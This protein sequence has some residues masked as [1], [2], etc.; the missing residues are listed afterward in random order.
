MI[1]LAI[2]GVI[3][4][5]ILALA[6]L[7]ALH[8]LRPDIHPGRTMIS[9]YAVGRHGWLMFVCFGGLA[10]ASLCLALV[11][12]PRL[13]SFLGRVG[14]VF[15]VAAGI[16][17]G[18]A[19]LCPMDP[20][21]EGPRRFSLRGK[22]HGLGFL[23]GTPC[24]L[25][26]VLLL[27]LSAGFHPA[28]ILLAAFAAMTWLSFGVVIWIMAL[29]GPGKAPDPNGPERFLGAPNRLFMVGFG[30]WLLTAAW[31]LLPASL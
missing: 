22:L 13:P 31:P 11:L 9:Q 28:R 5:V 19:A 7:A 23:A 4:A 8:V 1:F 25:L 24:M 16:G 18:V 12:S 30:L 29:V 6:A 15:L 3:G 20:I 17:L 27:S 10:V 2:R 26:A 21:A 14:L